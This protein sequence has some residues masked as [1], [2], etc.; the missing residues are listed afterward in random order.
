MVE[1][2]YGGGLSGR[3]SYAMM[4]GAMMICIVLGQA[5]RVGSYGMSMVGRSQRAEQENGN[6]ETAFDS[7]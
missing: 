6:T 2:E 5:T 7:A 1:V 4:P 3:K